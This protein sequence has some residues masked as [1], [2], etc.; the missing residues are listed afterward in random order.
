M[1][2]DPSKALAPLD[3]ALDA[4]L[5]EHLATNAGQQRYLSFVDWI[6]RVRNPTLLALAHGCTRSNETRCLQMEDAGIAVPQSWLQATST[7]DARVAAA[8][9]AACQELLLA[10]AAAMIAA[11]K[12]QI[13]QRTAYLF[14]PRADASACDCFEPAQPVC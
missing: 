1:S 3:S 7:R 8:I 10:K 4:D 6:S 11:G 9:K 2:L 13:Q 14:R 12:A 5:A